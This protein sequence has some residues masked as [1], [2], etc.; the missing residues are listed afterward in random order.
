M[1]NTIG[2]FY[3][4]P[5]DQILHR[6]T[7]YPQQSQPPQYMH[8]AIIR[9]TGIS[10]RQTHYRYFSY[11]WHQELVA[12]GV[13]V[14]PWGPAVKKKGSKQVSH[15]AIT[16]ATEAPL[17]LDKYG[18]LAPNTSRFLKSDGSATLAESQLEG[19]KK[20]RLDSLKAQFRVLRNKAGEEQ[21]DWKNSSRKKP[22]EDSNYR[23]GNLHFG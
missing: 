17:S 3:Y 10:G 8:L 22:H 13:A 21:L 7:D 9:E 20:E 11:R 19:K 6:L 12:E 23:S 16:Q 1:Y 5:M 15:G 4:R 14:Q 18:F 2:S